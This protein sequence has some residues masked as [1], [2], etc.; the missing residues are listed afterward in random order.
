MLAE[1]GRKYLRICALD[2][3]LTIIYLN[4][5]VNKLSILG[6]KWYIP[7]DYIKFKDNTPYNHRKVYLLVCISEY[8]KDKT[9]IIKLTTRNITLPKLPLIIKC[10]VLKYRKEGKKLLT[11]LVINYKQSKPLALTNWLNKMGSCKVVKMSQCKLKWEGK[12][13]EFVLY[14]MMGWKAIL[15]FHLTASSSLFLNL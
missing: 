1:M 4:A 6:I 15:L 10:I 3:A 13:G 14:L 7:K 12:G 11:K 8:K 2:L 5:S 9:Q